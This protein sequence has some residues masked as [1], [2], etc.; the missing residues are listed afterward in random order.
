LLTYAA[1]V[2]A[3]DE[4]LYAE[5]LTRHTIETD[6]LAGVRV[7]Y[8]QLR[9]SAD[10]KRL[11]VSL[12]RSQPAELKTRQEKLAFW[13]NAYNILAI[14]IVSQNYP[15]DGIKDIGS[16][17]N[18]VWDHTAGRIAGSNY[19]L[20]QIE[21]EI[22]RPMGEPRIHGA[23]VCASL[24]CP[25]LLREPFRAETLDA[26]LDA[27]T[28]TWLSDRRKGVRIDAARNAIVISKI[29]D[30]FEEDFEASGGVLPFIRAHLAEEPLASLGD[31]PRVGYFDYDWSLNRVQ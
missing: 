15:V 30:W 23:I 17:F 31:S 9:S 11:V 27:H 5:L 4:A 1:P 25:P 3:L 21:H 19:S 6:D 12:Q 20:G 8:A 28:R 24:S 29:F 22:L 13:I 10:W 16:F 18:P 7:D 26:Q 14:D 2:A